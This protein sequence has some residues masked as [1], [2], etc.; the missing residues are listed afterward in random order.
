MRRTSS[1]LGAMMLSIVAFAQ[2]CGEP[3]HETFVVTMTSLPERIDPFQ[4]LVNGFYYINL[5]LY[6]PIFARSS[7]T[8]E[9]TSEYLDLDETRALSPAMDTFRL[10]LRDGVTFSDG[11][12]IEP[13]DLSASLAQIHASQGVLPGLASM[14][15]HARC[16]LVALDEP[17]PFYFDKLTT[18]STTV[19][20]A[21]TEDDAVPTGRGDYRLRNRDAKDI[22]LTS[23]E[24]HRG[25][26]AVKFAVVPTLI[27]AVRA[28]AD[29]I[30]VMYWAP[31]KER[32]LRGFRQIAHPSLR[33]FA[34]MVSIPDV[35]LRQCVVA[36]IPARAFRTEAL[37]MR[38]E[39]T[40]GFLPNGALG[41]AVSFSPSPEACR[42]LSSSQRKPTVRFFNHMGFMHD[43]ISKFFQARA[44]RLPFHVKVEDH[45][46]E[47]VFAAVGGGEPIAYLLGF[48]TFS[49]QAARKGEPSMFFEPFLRRQLCTSAPSGIRDMLRAASRERRPREKRMRYEEMHRL[50]LASGCVLPLGQMPPVLYYPP[51]IQSLEFADPIMG[52]PKVAS[53][54]RKP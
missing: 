21:G 46:L 6:T 43:A 18:A 49:S 28:R 51:H 39:E 30:N 48:G 7:A 36:S 23:S 29:D 10:C 26:E 14:R 31:D 9:L 34:L 54:R 25:Y 41:S 20:K 17:D 47:E 2:G 11:T 44:S 33:S 1:M 24:A 50:L 5:Q 4:P 52:Y 8:N 37:G 45:T 53:I 16:L 13:G 19:I 32:V 15:V 22:T 40:V 12:P 35:A 42:A 27:D 38:L 3:R